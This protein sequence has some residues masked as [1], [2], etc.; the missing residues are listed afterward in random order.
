MTRKET[1][2][3]TPASDSPRA[4]V[5][6]WVRAQIADREEV[7]IPDLRNQAIEHFEKDRAFMRSLLTAFM[8][9]SLYDIVQHVVGSTR[10][11]TLL[12]DT[13]VTE[14]GIDQRVSA[15]RASRWDR[16][17]EHVGDK[18]LRLMDMT[19]ED[20][21]QAITEREQRIESERSVVRILSAIYARL[22]GGQR[23]RERFTAAEIEQLRRSLDGGAAAA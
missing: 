10:G 20:V 4:Q 16:W 18:H 3:D 12:G 2:M 17:L 13:V 6:R 21:L 9:T 11:L 8:R 19:R 15:A 23:V 7:S 14:D 22:E 5:A 1:Q